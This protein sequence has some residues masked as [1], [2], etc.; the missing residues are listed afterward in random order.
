DEANQSM[1]V[2][3]PDDQLSLAIREINPRMVMT[4]ISG[5]GQ[6]GPYA[7]RAGFDTIGQAMGGLMGMTGPPDLPPMDAGGAIC[8]I[9]SG[10]FGA[11][12]TMMALYHQKCTGMGQHVE[13]TLMESVV[14]LM[15]LNLAFYVGGKPVEKGGLFGLSRTSGAGRFVTKDNVYIIIMAQMD[16]FWRIM[17]RLIGREDLDDTPGYRTRDER[18]QRA[19]EI[20]D[21]MQAWVIQHTIDEVEA[22]MEELGIPYGRIQTIPEVLE[23]PHLN[24]RGRFQEI[25][26]YGDLLKLLSPYPILSETPGS[27]RTVW[28]RPGQHNKEIY[29]DI[30]G[31]SQTELDKMKNEG[32]I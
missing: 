17:A 31:F 21:L 22:I 27:I 1:G 14:F 2:V 5:F 20:E 18:A 6:T 13:S 8:D 7:Q 16:N 10:V 9:S 29:G 4:S 3:V 12:G 19:Q 15:G 11:L 30:L 24:A 32:I 25:N 28:P 23:D 26:A